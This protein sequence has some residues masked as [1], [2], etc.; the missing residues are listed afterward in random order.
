[1][2]NVTIVIKVLNEE[3]NIARAIQSALK[4]LKGYKGQ[5]VLV[6]SLSTDKTIEI[7]KKYPIEIIQLK[8]IKDRSCGIGPQIG[9]LNSKGD[10]IY[11]LDGDMELNPEFISNAIKELESDKMLAGVSGRIYEINTNNIVFRRRKERSSYKLMKE[12]YVGK[13][14][15]GGLYRKEAITK[16]GYFSNPY[17]HSYEESDLGHRLTLA[18]YKLKI[19][20]VDMIKHYGDTTTSINIFLNRWKSRY[21]WGCGELLRYHLGKPTFFKVVS[22]LRLYLLVILWWVVFFITIIFYEIFYNLFYIQLTITLI[23]L[24]LFLIKKRSLVELIFSIFSWNITA[25]ALIFGF[26]Q[27]QKDITAKIETVRIK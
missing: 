16:V 22:E 2:K 6:D 19:I 8:N 17:L 7:A 15:M 9:Y 18:G 11:I 4:A 26:L 5:V 21:L 20:P 1:M 24:I 3:E 12:K 23:F 27:K 25:L 13:L 10:Y 14:M